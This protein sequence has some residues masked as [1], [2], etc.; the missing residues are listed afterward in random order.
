MVFLH[1]VH[2]MH[3]LNSFLNTMHNILCFTTIGSIKEVIVSSS[4][5]APFITPTPVTSITTSG[6]LCLLLLYTCDWRH[7]L[8]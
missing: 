8:L 5:S 4:E 3:T 7:V 2:T 6:E 1:H